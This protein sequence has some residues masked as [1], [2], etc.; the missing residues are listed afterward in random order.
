MTKQHPI[1]C[2]IGAASNGN[3][4][5]SEAGIASMK[6]RITIAS[7]KNHTK[8]NSPDHPS[9]SSENSICVS[10]DVAD[11]SDESFKRMRQSIADSKVIT[12][13]GVHEM[14]R[15]YL[16]ERREIQASR[17][18]ESSTNFATGATSTCVSVD[19]DRRHGSSTNSSL[20]AGGVLGDKFLRGLATFASEEHSSS[21]YSTATA[22]THVNS[23]S[24][25]SEV[26]R[27]YSSSTNLAELSSAGTDTDLSPSATSTP[28]KGQRRLKRLSK[29]AQEMVAGF[30]GDLQREN[31]DN[32]LSDD[33]TPSIHVAFSKNT[34]G[35]ADTSRSIFSNTKAV[36]LRGLRGEE[37]CT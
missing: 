30:L 14:A 33:S 18:N 26:L 28:T 20:G 1:F 11:M 4:L 17:Q 5:S 10:T 27:Q 3:I 13:A 9:T 16:K 37:E 35:P 29:D 2:H 8:A 6:Q 23:T 21:I 12:S 31:S 22:D 19:N 25:S 32:F 36:L 15:R 24:S 7:T 34:C